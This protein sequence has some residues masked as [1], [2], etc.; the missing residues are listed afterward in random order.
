MSG[1]VAEKVVNRYI[2]GSTPFVGLKQ[3]YQQ[4]R[5]DD[6]L[7]HLSR[8]EIRAII[9]REIPSVTLWA[10][11][12]VRVPRR[13]YYVFVIDEV[14]QCDTLF[15]TP[16]VLRSNRI[17]ALLLVVDIASRFVWIKPIVRKTSEK[18][19]Q[20]L[21]RLFDETKRS[22]QVKVVICRNKNTIF[23]DF[24]PYKVIGGLNLRQRMWQSS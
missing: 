16:K 3:F 14:W 20:A 10:N 5:A 7:K 11:R 19:I 24:R 12:I 18:I 9:R 6:E 21:Q 8:E 13:A 15:F 4:I 23:S 2:Y 1:E 17:A 22:P